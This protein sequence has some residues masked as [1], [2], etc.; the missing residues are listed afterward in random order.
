MKHVLVAMAAST[1]L[2]CGGTAWAKVTAPAAPKSVGAVEASSGR[3]FRG[4]G[5]KT[6]QPFSVS[7]PST[8]YWSAN[9]GVFQAFPSGAQTHGTVNSSAAKGWTYLPSGRYLLQIN[10]I[11]SW[12][13]QVVPGIVFPQHLGGGWVGYR[14]N[15][16]MELPPFRAPRSEQLYWQANGGIFQIFSDDYTGVSVNSQGRRGTTYMSRGVQQLQINALE[17]WQIAWRP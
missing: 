8:M 2:A 12:V 11:G 10:A 1:L 6:L 16:G 4:D 3:I 14:G 15:G 9:G 17:A 13:I 7:R 5:G